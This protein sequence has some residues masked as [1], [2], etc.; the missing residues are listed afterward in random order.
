MVT[1]SEF[2]Q[3]MNELLRWFTPISLTDFREWV[4]GAKPLPCNP[5]LITFDDGYLNNLTQAAPVLA[6]LGIPATIFLTTGYI[7][8]R[9]IL[10]PTEI[11]L[12]IFLWARTR[13]PL[14]HGGDAE[15]PK[16]QRTRAE[17]AVAIEE[18]C[19]QLSFDDCTAYLQCLGSRNEDLADR[20]EAEFGGCGRE[21]FAFLD[22]DQARTLAQSGFEVG[23]HTVEHPI[24]SRASRARVESDL[25]IS[26][27]IIQ[28]ELGR[29]CFAFA[30]PNGRLCDVSHTAIEAAR[31]TAYEMA[32][33][34]TGGLTDRSVAPLLFDRI[35]IP[36]RLS[37]AEFQTR[38]SGV[39]D[40]LRRLSL[41]PRERLL[42]AA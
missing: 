3:Q 32:F 42:S 19:K 12:R 27:E 14:P 2:R 16:S 38:A 29:E 22:W 33:L 6:K 34:L 8:Q 39:H 31:K 23:S 40:G 25:Q 41:S 18:T 36:G 5:V 35:W 24:L 37:R 10:W 30:Y 20:L 21:L 1:M 26:K 28:R 17:F 15:L 13:V 7:G 9:R 11:Y 4:H